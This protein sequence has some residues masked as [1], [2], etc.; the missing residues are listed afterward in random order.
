MIPFIA[1][2]L[3]PPAFAGFTGNVCEDDCIVCGQ[4]VAS[5]SG[6]TLLL[7]KRPTLH[8]DRECLQRY[9]DA[10]RVDALQ[11][12]LW[13]LPESEHATEHAEE[14]ITKLL[15]LGWTLAEIADDPDDAI[16]TADRLQGRERRPADV[17]TLASNDGAYATA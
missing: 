13:Y 16:A 9:V 7:P 17:H 5:R 8:A 2:R 10:R 15:A 1:R 3:L 4:S 12:L 11:A 14:I 6:V